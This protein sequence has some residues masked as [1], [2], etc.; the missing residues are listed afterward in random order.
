MPTKATTVDEYLAE[1]PEDRRAALGAV[2]RVILANL[3]ADYEEGIQYGMIGYFVPHRIFPA[4][5][6]GAD[7]NFMRFAARVLIKIV[8]VKA[9]TLRCPRQTS[10]GSRS[11]LSPE[12]RGNLRRSSFSLLGR[13]WPKAG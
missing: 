11:T 2:R 3:D 7:L 10:G 5:F 6:K 1:L 8:D 9:L 13:R 4:D 12:G